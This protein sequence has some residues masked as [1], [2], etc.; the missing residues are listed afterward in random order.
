MPQKLV[1][2][3]PAGRKAYLEILVPQL[4]Q[5]RQH[6]H[7]HHFWVNTNLQEDITYLESL[8]RQYPDFFKLNRRAFYD[9]SRPNNSIWQY[10]QDY[11]DADT[12]YLRL[13]DDIC[14][15]APDAI[16]NIAAY[17]LAHPEPF[18]VLGNIVNNAICSYYHQQRGFLPLSWGRVGKMCMDPI[19][20][21]SKLF[22]H[23][24]HN[25]FLH[26]IRNGTTDRWKFAPQTLDGF[27]RFSINVI[28]WFGKDMA[29]VPER[30]IPNLYVQPLTHPLNQSGMN[31][32][33]VALTEY[34]PA[35]FNRPNVIC[36]DALFGH[37]AYYTQRTYLEGITTLLQD[38]HSLADPEFARA[39][40]LKRHVDRVVKPLSVVGSPRAWKFVRRVARNT[41][42]GR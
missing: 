37:F 20:W 39:Y 3:T 10:F 2:V 14:Y 1:S 31:N 34:L 18:L 28:C 11:T 13:D 40:Q 23:R 35:K 15:I 9:A 27:E 22:A 21:D 36:G 16:P 30:L 42:A 4:L 26:D 25:R 17:R 19:G 8:A 32:E 7:E 6:I 5:N 33:E 24:L 41:I 12:I 29:Q 38:Y